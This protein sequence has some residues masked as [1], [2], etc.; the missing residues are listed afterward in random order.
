[1]YRRIRPNIDRTHVVIP[2]ILPAQ[3]GTRSPEFREEARVSEAQET[4]TNEGGTRRT[5]E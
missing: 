5:A 2:A 3:R 1:M 4:L